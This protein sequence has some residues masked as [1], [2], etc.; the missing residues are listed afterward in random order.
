[1]SLKERNF[2]IGEFANFHPKKGVLIAG[3]C[4]ALRI[5]HIL[6]CKSN[7]IDLHNTHRVTAVAMVTAV[8]VV[9]VGNYE[10]KRHSPIKLA[11]ECSQIMAGVYYVVTLAT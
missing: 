4:E 5:Q 2:H 3:C 9:A 7:D 10:A 8:E 6:K 11:S 1:M